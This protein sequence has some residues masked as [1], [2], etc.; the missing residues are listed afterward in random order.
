LIQR[1]FTVGRPDVARVLDISYIP[2]G[3][4]WL[5]LATVLDLEPRRLLGYSMT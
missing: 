1:G 2:T 3:D 5:Y 4:G